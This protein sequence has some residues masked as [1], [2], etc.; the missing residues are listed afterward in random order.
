MSVETWSHLKVDSL[1][2]VCLGLGFGLNTAQGTDRNPG[3]RSEKSCSL[4]ARN[5]W[6]T[7]GSENGEPKTRWLL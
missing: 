5:F 1:V 3:S 2:K 4:P 6:R 7:A